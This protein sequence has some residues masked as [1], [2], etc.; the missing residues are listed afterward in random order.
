MNHSFDT[1]CIHGG[2]KN[3]ENSFRAISTPIYQSASFAHIKTGHN[4]SGFDYTRESNPTRSQLENTVSSLEGASDTIAFSSGMAAVAACFDHFRPGDRILCS[5]DLYGGVV[6]LNTRVLE[7]NGV[8][9]DYSDTR[10]L[11]EAAKLLTPQT[12]AIY[13]ETPSNPMMHVTD[14]RKAAHLAHEHGALLI[15]DNTFLSPYFQNPIAL[16]ADVVIH[17]G[18]KFLAGHNDTVCG[19]LCSADK[20][21]AGEFRLT[22]KT[23]GAVLGPFD[24]WLVLR[25]IKTLAVRMERQQKSAVR[26]A[27]WLKT[28]PCVRKVYYV[29]LPDSPGYDVN[30]AQARGAG[31]MISFS[32]DSGATA[33]RLLGKVKLITF[34]ESL[35]GVESLI[36]YPIAQTHTDVPPETRRRLGITECLLRL[37]VG[38]ESPEDLIADLAQGLE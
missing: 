27:E 17:S 36:T 1:R 26:I 22:S 10:D 14:I 15:V 20:E 21:L 5:D 3:A 32:V 9:V 19:F 38:L 33:E 2:E 28:Q 16:G 13:I 6:R 34:A 31:S 23:T 12:K 11:S 8:T 37:S 35:G 30:R 29:G 25:G 18:T 4:E 24:S 7:K